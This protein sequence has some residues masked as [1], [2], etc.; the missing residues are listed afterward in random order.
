MARLANSLTTLRNQINE[1]WPNRNKASDGW[2]GDAAHAKEKSEHNPN[3]AGVVTALDITHDPKN[4]VHGGDIAEALNDDS[5]TWYV[6]WNR[7]IWDV[8][9]IP[10]WGR[11]P[12][13]RHVH[14]SVRQDKA[15]Y[16]NANQ[17]NI[18]GDMPASQ[19][20][21]D[22]TAIRQGYNG[23]LLR[24]P[25]RQ[26]INDWL[27]NKA[28]LEGF[29]RSLASSSERK[30]VEAMFRAGHQGS[31]AIADETT[32]RLA[33]NNGLNRDA[34]KEE[35][36]SWLK[37]KST[38]EALQRAIGASPERQKLLGKIGK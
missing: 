31:Q 9:W 21:I 28:T 25:N 24:D 12:H 3:S 1:A 11:N 8:K 35:V 29:Q 26:E 27:A 10:Y 36:A 6:I 22:E 20:V 4:G 33:Y 13:D 34:T 38:V 37:H 7:K 18:G 2:I 19:D 15:N 5:R 16:D 17:W 32:I 14:I 23:W 30:A